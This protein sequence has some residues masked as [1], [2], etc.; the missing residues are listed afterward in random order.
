MSTTGTNPPLISIQGQTVGWIHLAGTENAYA[1]NPATDGCS[2][3]PFGGTSCNGLF[4]NTA[5]TKMLNG[6]NQVLTAVDSGSAG[7]FD[8]GQFDNDGPDGIP[9]SGD[10]DGVVDQVIFIHSE[11]DGACG[12][13]SSNHLWSHRAGALSF[14]THT[15]RH[16]ST[17][18]YITV[19]N[20]TL[21]SGVGGST[22]CNTSAIMP[23]GTAAHETGHA[24]GLPDLYDVS[25][26]S[27]GVGEWSLMGSGNY[28]SP[29]SPSRMDAWSLSQLGWVTV[30]PL[31]ANGT[32]SF[33]PAPVSDT[34][35][36][37]RVQVPPGVAS[38]GS[39]PGGLCIQGEYYL[40]E[41]RQGVQ[42]DTGV[43]KVHCARSGLNFP[44]NCHGGLAI[45]HVD[46]LKTKQHGF[47]AD[48][49]VT[50]GN[51]Q[52]V[53]LVQADG[54]NQLQGT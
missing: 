26:A 22:A 21:Q 52:G 30:A 24:F 42:A 16:G 44:T 37:V 9:N 15:L 28:T 2:G 14:T 13:S 19:R 27:E 3:N 38:C 23:I 40:L 1:G 46:S 6:L 51:P 18:Q 29:F 20:Y 36:M 49:T 5:F 45:W 4:S 12:P 31:T 47:N 50:V 41:N 32:Y 25:G 39:Q 10:D 33:G 17:T 43:I 7:H 35:F 11:E 34:T 54:L 48:N 53:L 8:W